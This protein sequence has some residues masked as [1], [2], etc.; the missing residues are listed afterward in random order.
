MGNQNWRPLTDLVIGLDLPVEEAVLLDGR[1]AVH[2]PRQQVPR[3]PA[4]LV[5]RPE[6]RRR[7]PTVNLDVLPA[8]RKSIKVLY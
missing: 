6:H 8:N 4:R 3:P 5:R 2:R 1:V 7:R